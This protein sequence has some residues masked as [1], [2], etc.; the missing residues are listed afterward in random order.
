MKHVAA[1]WGR[2]RR[3]VY[4]SVMWNRRI[5]GHIFISSTSPINILLYSL[6]PR[7]INYYI[8]WCYIRQLFR[9]LTKEFTINSSI[10]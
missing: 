9:W 5:Y 1:V 10:L 2:T 4:L 8:C 3:L 7:N 6:V